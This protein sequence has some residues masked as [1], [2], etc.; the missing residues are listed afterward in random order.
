MLFERMV[1]NKSAFQEPV[2]PS[3]K[4]ENTSYELE[5]RDL[6]GRDKF[7]CW[8][9]N[10]LLLSFPLSA[11]FDMQFLLLVISFLGVSCGLAH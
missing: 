2:C 4:V 10:S 1:S 5:K 9:V 8:F 7:Y 11:I 3:L 6:G